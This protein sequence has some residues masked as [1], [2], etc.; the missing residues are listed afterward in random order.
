MKLIRTQI[1]LG[2]LL[3]A[4]GVAA[5][6]VFTRSS[7]L[8]A[9]RPVTIRLAHWQI[10][11]GPPD[12]IAAAIKRYEE[13][14]P[15]VKVEQLLIPGATVY[16][17]WM[18]SNLAGETGPDLLE[19]GA[20]IPGQKDIP[21][22]YF[23]PLTAELAKPN[24][25]NRGTSQ[26]GVPW[27]KTFHDN[28][29][30][31]RRDSPDP[32]QIYAVTISET[33]VRLFCNIKLLREATGSTAAPKTFDDLRRIFARVREH[34]RRTGR[35]IH[36]L[37]GSRDNG[38]WI[39]GPIFSTP[40]LG[41]NREIDD[42]GYSYLYNRDVLAAYLA[43]R[44]NYRRPEVKA[45]LLLVRELAQAMKPGF[46]Q[47][48]RDDAMLEFFRG[49]AVFIY[50][51]TWD[52][53]SLRRIAPF[54]VVPMRLP[55][56]TADDPEAGRY[57]AGTLGEGQGETSFAFYLN[58]HSAHKEETIDFLRFLTS[59]E[60]NQ[61]FTDHSL[62]LPSVNGVK[63]PEEIKEFRTYQE[64]FAFGQASYDFIGSGVN[65]E[66]NRNFHRLVGEQGGVD[67]FA[68][69]LDQIMPEAIRADLQTEMRNT[70]LLVKPQ[71]TVIVASAELADDTAAGVRLRT[72]QHEI[73]AGQTMSEGLALQMRLQL[74]TTK[75]AP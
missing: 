26:E 68:E 21:A 22:R 32:G 20:W 71:D 66:W 33:T 18:R 27:E 5:Y 37:A 15:R 11:R 17:Q 31:A 53:T 63:V 57:V 51:G 4:Y 46:L 9:A 47:L 43:G 10:E 41:I 73:E 45:G 48:H 62:W 14:N 52:A 49:E 69:L 64:G 1:S 34:A 58:K 39:A 13:L 35:P 61:L 59:V 36:G 29:I 28:L 56:V 75:Q 3:L 54:Q 24:P 16:P 38:L 44:W 72:R 25:Y 74:E 50:T 65:M 8:V 7:P 42:N 23:T 6:W 19:W 60:G 55:A 70:L 12:G 30:G 67:Q 2:L 40:L